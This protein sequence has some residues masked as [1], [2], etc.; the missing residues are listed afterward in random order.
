MI[1]FKLN[2]AVL[3]L[4]GK[5]FFQENN[6]ISWRKFEIFEICTKHCKVY[7]LIQI[8]LNLLIYYLVTKV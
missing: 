7:V 1:H 2:A 3:F 4:I 6:Y 5:L 8:L